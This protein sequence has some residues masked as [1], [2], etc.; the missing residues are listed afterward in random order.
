MSAPIDMGRYA[1]RW[2]QVFYSPGR[3]FADL[4]TEQSASESILILIVI[5]SVVLIAGIVTLRLRWIRNGR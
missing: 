5:V 4:E 1:R 3:A 2:L